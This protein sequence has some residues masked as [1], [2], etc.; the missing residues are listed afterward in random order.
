MVALRLGGIGNAV[1]QVPVL[2]KS[3]VNLKIAISTLISA[4]FLFNSHRI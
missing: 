4:F 1:S 3:E 2:V